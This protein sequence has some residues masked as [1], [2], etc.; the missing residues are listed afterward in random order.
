M[1]QWLLDLIIIGAFVLVAVALLQWMGWTIDPIVWRIA[2]I[3]LGAIVL[4]L[5][6]RF[7]WPILVGG[8]LPALR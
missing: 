6:I 7:L 5:I 8:S 1:E 3:I 2:G 4:V